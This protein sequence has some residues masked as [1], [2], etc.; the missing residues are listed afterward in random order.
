M[1][2]AADIQRA[3]FDA[4][5]SGD[6]DAVRALFHTEYEFVDEEGVTHGVDGSVEKVRVYSSAF[7]DMEFDIH[8]QLELGDVC[9]MEA[10]VIA[11]HTGTLFGVPATGRRISME[12]CN[13][14]EVRDG[15]IYREHDYNDN[16]AVMRQLGVV[17]AQA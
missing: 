3:Y 1:G 8:R 12:Y 9:V 6:V 14:I 17:P 16:L 7:P 15:L 5:R 4:I 2:M 11:T 10:T 13:V